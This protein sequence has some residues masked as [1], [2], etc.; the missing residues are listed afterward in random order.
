VGFGSVPVGSR[1]ARHAAAK[2]GKGRNAWNVFA[3][4]GWRAA[5]QK[6][7]SFRSVRYLAFAASRSTCVPSRFASLI[8]ASGTVTTLL[9]G[10]SLSISN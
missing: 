10:A 9:M 6:E 7:K 8:L 3:L 1:P 5:K 2:G 4:E